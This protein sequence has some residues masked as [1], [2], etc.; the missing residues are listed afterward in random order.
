MTRVHNHVVSMTRGEVTPLVHGRV[1]LQDYRLGL[2]TCT[3]FI[4]SKYGGV[5]RMPGTLDQNACTT[6][7]AASRLIPF[8]FNESQAYALE[9]SNLKLRFHTVDGVIESGGS[10]VEVVTPY[11]QADLWKI[12]TDSIGDVVYVTCD[13]YENRTLTRSSDT[14]WT[15]ATFEALNGP[16]LPSPGA[17]AA[18]M[19][20][21]D[22]GHAWPAMTTNTAPSGTASTTTTTIA[23]GGTG[24]ASTSAWKSFDNERATATLDGAA[25]RGYIQY[26]YGAGVEKVIT[27]YALTAESTDV[28]KARNTAVNWTL[29]AQKDGSAAWV[30]L[31]QHRGESDWVSGETRVFEITNSTAYRV[32]RIETMGAADGGG[33][34]ASATRYPKWE[35][36]LHVDDQAAFTVTASA[37]TG[38]NNDTG[39]Q[40]TDVGRLI[41]VMADDGFWRV[42]VITARASTT[43]V[44]AK[45]VGPAPLT[46]GSTVAAAWQLQA[47]SDES[48]WPKRVGKHK[49]R[50]AFFNTSDQPRGGWL[51]VS[52]DFDNFGVSDPL[53]DDDAVA[54]DLTNGRMD[55]ILWATS[56][57]TDLLLGTVGGI[58]VVNE[59]DPGAVFSPANA[60]EE[61]ATD[62]RASDVLPVWVSNILIFAGKA[63]QRLHET[64]FSAD[65]GGY[66]VR[67]LTM[68]AEHIFRGKVR[69]VHYQEIPSDL[70]WVVMEDGIVAACTYD[71]QQQVFGVSR[72]EIPGTLAGV[73]SMCV[74]PDDDGDASL[75]VTKRYVDGA[76]QYRIEKVTFP[77]RGPASV[78][79]RPVYLMAAARYQGAA[80]GTFTGLDHLEG[81][82]VTIYEANEGRDWGTAVVVS[83][84]VKAPNSY[85]TTD[86]YIGLAYESVI[87]TLRPP[88]IPEDGGY[89]GRPTSILEVHVD[90]FEAYG[91]Y[92]GDADRAAESEQLRTEADF[93]ANRGEVY[94]APTL[95]D[96]MLEVAVDGGWG[97]EARVRIGTDAPFPATIRAVMVTTDR[98][99]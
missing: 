34:S 19:T 74:L 64:A 5:I 70:L 62:V 23:S 31:D 17:G 80:T 82:T 26:D 4:V 42:L 65:D 32:Y 57:G 25:G 1:D 35:A 49:G 61:G 78:S 47:W 84:S 58:R 85:T 97:K 44:S 59:R 66:I 38:I 90:V 93:A 88:G 37:V 98:G 22:T 96:G 20:L 91:L 72:I 45:V 71:R 95:Y 27:G 33:G 15:L 29:K 87:E 73:E 10:P 9:F 52:D 40:T 18:S 56:N 99:T 14:S 86:A 69:E 83:G 30:T 11:L 12:Q 89:M 24:T 51:S 50:L 2:H 76:L 3:N 77:W 39:F 81:E 68:L 16:W 54:F 7:T 75:M 92:G 67:E 13:G 48:G 63:K 43:S 6:E 21:G 46:L 55:D 94:F 79:N 41:R 28:D 8:I 36:L 53:V 60:E